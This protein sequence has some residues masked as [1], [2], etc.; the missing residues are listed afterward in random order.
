MRCYQYIICKKRF[1]TVF[2]ATDEQLTNN[3][4]PSE[5][6]YKE[7]CTTHT[8]SEAVL[9]SL[10]IADIQSKLQLIVDVM[11]GLHLD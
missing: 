8:I 4:K 3:P 2:P 11:T 7:N 9:E 5:M 6:I 1:F 10:V